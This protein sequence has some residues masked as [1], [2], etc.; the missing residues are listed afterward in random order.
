MKHLG[1]ILAILSSLLLT[2]H[3]NDVTGCGGFVVSSVNINL[4]APIKIKLYVFSISQ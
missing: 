1:L 2:A 4:G 3:T